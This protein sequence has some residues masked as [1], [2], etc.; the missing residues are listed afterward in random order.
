LGWG[1]SHLI[2]ASL[3]RLII[4]R[5]RNMQQTDGKRWQLGRALHL[6]S[7]KMLLCLGDH[8][9]KIPTVGTGKCLSITTSVMTAMQISHP[10][11]VYSGTK[12]HTCKGFVAA[13]VLR[14]LMRLYFS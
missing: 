12:Q 7:K 3:A 13:V 2:T 5:F 6:A 14:I 11:P 10:A 8:W 1:Y 4:K 9:P